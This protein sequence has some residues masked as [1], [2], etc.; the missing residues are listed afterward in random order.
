MDLRAEFDRLRKLGVKFNIRTLRHFAIVLINESTSDT[1]H[2]NMKDAKYGKLMDAMVTRRWIQT[3]TNRHGF[4]SRALTENHQ[5]SA[6]RQLF[7][8]KEVAFHLGTLK[9]EFETGAIF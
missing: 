1:Y 4:V 9:R 7:T 6:A 2:D 3:S 8:D 5:M